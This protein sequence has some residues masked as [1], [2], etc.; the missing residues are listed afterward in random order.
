MAQSNNTT[1]LKVA[2]VIFAVVSII[3]GVILWIFPG[4]MVTL[5]GGNPVDFAWLR[6]SGGAFIALGI[7]ALMVFRKPEKQDIFV[8]TMALIALFKG[9]GFLFSWIMKESSGPT[10]FIAV[11]TIFWLVISC[12]F[13]WG[14]QQAKGI[15]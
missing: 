12:L 3:V 5:V 7:G 9:L 1:L 6:W 4:T 11:E 8:F 15:L 10:I 2:L 14:R 13:W